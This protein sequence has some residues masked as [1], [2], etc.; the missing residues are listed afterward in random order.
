MVCG[1]CSKTD[2]PWPEGFA[3]KQDGLLFG[4]IR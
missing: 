2:E 4:G 3:A 1:D